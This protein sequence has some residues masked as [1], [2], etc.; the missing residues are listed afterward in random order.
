MRG[1]RLL[2]AI[3]V[4]VL[5]AGV[6]AAF[7]VDDSNGKAT[8]QQVA[9]LQ[10]AADVVPAQGTVTIKF[11]MNLTAAGRTTRFE[12]EQHQDFANQRSTGQMRLPGLGSIDIVGVGTIGWLRGDAIKTSSGGPGWWRVEAAEG[13]FPNSTYT[14]S[15]APNG[16]DYLAYLR[17]VGTVTDEGNTTVDGIA[18]THY[19]AELDLSKIFET[20]G[21]DQQQQQLQAL[22]QQGTH[23]TC[24]ADAYIDDHGLPRRVKMTIGGADLEIEMTLDFVDYGA[25]VDVTPP[26]D[27]DVVRTF[28]VSSLTDATAVGA[29]LAQV[30]QGGG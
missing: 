6:I 29:Q 16:I 24:V 11:S 4:T 25:P 9:T 21:L 8:A 2:R 22:D 19:R 14:A 10:R 28:T 15:G 18:T 20:A 30:L 5:L 1:V 3:S 17:H 23:L 26:P 12:G 7:T 27:E 13:A